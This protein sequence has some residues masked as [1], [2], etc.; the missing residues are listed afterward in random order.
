MNNIALV[1]T[2]FAVILF[3]R[4]E[5]LGYHGVMVLLQAGFLV[6]ALFLAATC[7]ARWLGSPERDDFPSADNACTSQQTRQT[8]AFRFG[9][10]LNRVLNGRLG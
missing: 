8:F 2:I 7:I 6:T 1:A 10:S 5:E 4:G 3:A 9:K